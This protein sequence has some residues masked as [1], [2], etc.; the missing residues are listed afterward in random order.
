MKTRPVAT[1]SGAISSTAIFIIMKAEPHNMA[2]NTSK[3]ISASRALLIV[4][5]VW[6]MAA[7]VKLPE[8]QT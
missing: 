7:N 2:Q 6:D 3:Q 8:L 4:V 1:V 5:E